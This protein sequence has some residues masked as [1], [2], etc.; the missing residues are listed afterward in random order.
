[1]PPNLLSA[2]KANLTLRVFLL[3]TWHFIFCLLIDAKSASRA[4]RAAF[5]VCVLKEMHKSCAARE[6]GT[7]KSAQRKY[8][9]AIKKLCVCYIRIS[10]LQWSQKG[11]R[12]VK[13]IKYVSFDF[14]V[15]EIFLAEDES[16]K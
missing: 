2:V 13:N 10:A 4:N 6:Q 7:W 8:K 14:W 1:M 11:M 9:P 16:D 3:F 12:K 5:L 15:G